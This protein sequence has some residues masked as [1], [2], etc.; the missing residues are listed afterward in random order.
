M[1]CEDCETDAAKLQRIEEAKQKK[2]WWII[3]FFLLIVAPLIVIVWCVYKPY[4]CD[5]IAGK[6]NLKF[7]ASAGDSFGGVTCIA[8]IVTVI[9]VYFAYMS[10]REELKETNRAFK[11][12]LRNN[13]R[14][15]LFSEFKSLCE[16][17]DGKFLY[18][19]FNPD[20][21]VKILDGVETRNEHGNPLTTQ[22]VRTASVIKIFFKSPLFISDFFKII[23]LLCMIEEYCADNE[24][25]FLTDNDK[26][27]LYN[28][29]SLSMSYQYGHF[30]QFL[31]KFN[32][33]CGGGHCDM[34]TVKLAANKWMNHTKYK[35]TEE[36]I[37]Q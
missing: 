3:A 27:K 33:Y 4:L 28:Y 23:A 37:D 14:N 8:S 6:H 2:E 22:R 21:I 11:E 31:F 7:F 10:Q 25:G 35:S 29:L 16:S 9:L 32:V 20:D 18:T 15:N 1:S 26:S 34:K 24:S 5:I 19:E 17:L 36:L 12:Q 30:I 13:E